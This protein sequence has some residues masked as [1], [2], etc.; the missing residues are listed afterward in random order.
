MAEGRMR[1]TWLAIVFAK[2]P[3]SKDSFLAVP[4]QENCL[5]LLRL[6]MYTLL[7]IDHLIDQRLFQ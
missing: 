2:S 5:Y 6:R 7:A 3:D 1:W 4:S